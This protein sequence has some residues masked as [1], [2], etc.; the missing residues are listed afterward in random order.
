MKPSL[1]R[2]GYKIKFFNSETEALD[3]L[4]D[5]KIKVHVDQIF[6]LD[7]AKKAFKHQEVGHPRGKVVLKIRD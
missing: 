3:W 7:Q 2:M 6:S 5:G 4:T 1:G